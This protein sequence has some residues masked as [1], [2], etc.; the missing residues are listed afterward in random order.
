MSSS[1]YEMHHINNFMSD[2]A[3]DDTQY[4]LMTINRCRIAIVALMY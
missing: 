3:T 1:L 2:H 4:T